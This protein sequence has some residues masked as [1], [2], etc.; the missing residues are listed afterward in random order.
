[1]R[2][3][4]QF[5]EIPRIEADCDAGF[6]TDFWLFAVGVKGGESSG[7]CVIGNKGARQNL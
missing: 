1:L 5:L 7:C 3:W 4:K 6:K 2:Y